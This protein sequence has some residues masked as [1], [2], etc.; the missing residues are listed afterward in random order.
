MPNEKINRCSKLLASKEWRIG[1]A[2][3]A[4]AG[5]LSYEFSL[6]PD[7]GKILVGG[8]VCY[9]ASI[10]TGILG[11]PEEFVERFTPESAEVTKA[12]ADA[13]YEAHPTE[14]CVAITGLTTPGGSESEEKPVGTM[15]IHVIF[16]G[17]S[18]A[19]RIVFKGS[20]E[21]IVGQTVDRVAELVMEGISKAD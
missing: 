2:E 13:I 18:V 15:F 21:E 12:M 10:K 7:S 9:D 14:V 8:I 6:A 1:F 17:Y 20:P 19:D 4:T 16:P 5:R 3:S 11:I